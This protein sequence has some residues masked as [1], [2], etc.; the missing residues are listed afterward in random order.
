MSLTHNQPIGQWNVSQ[1]IS[2][3]AMLAEAKSFNSSLSQWTSVM[4][5]I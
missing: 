3:W 2:M 5:H 1:V 4:R